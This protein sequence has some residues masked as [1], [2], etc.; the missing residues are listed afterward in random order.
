MSNKRIFDLIKNEIDFIPGDIV[1]FGRYSQDGDE[2]EPIRWIVLGFDHEGKALLLSEMI[3]DCRPYHEKEENVTWGYSSL[4]AWLNYD[5][6]PA[7]FTREEGKRI[8]TVRVNNPPNLTYQ[9]GGGNP[10]N[11]K[12]FCLSINEAKK[13]F[14]GDRD[15]KGDPTAFAKKNGAYE[16]DITG[17]G[18]WW[19]RS[20]GITNEFAASVDEAGGISPMGDPVCIEEN[21]VRPAIFVDLQQ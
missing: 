4:R 9:T 8:A 3:L 20:P 6:L 17:R 11:D 1:R 12:V 15:R 7:A 14:S 10:S 16:N 18:Q 21:G 13:Y 19:L 5:F 2:P